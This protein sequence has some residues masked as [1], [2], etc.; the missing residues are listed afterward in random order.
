VNSL[1]GTP[2][3]YAL[4]QAGQG[5]KLSDQNGNF[6][7]EDISTN[8][9]NVAAHKPGF[10]NEQELSQGQGQRVGRV[11]PQANTMVSLSNEPTNITIPLT[12]E[13]VIS[14]HVENSEGEPLEGLPVQ[15]RTTQ[16]VNG[17][18]MWQ[19][20]GGVATD[21]DG[22][23]RVAN[24]RPGTYYV[25]VGPNFS[26]RAMQQ[27][28]AANEKLEV[29]PAEYYPGVRDM[30]AAT[31][32]SLNPGQHASIEMGMKRVPGYRIS[33]MITGIASKFGGIFLADGDGDNTSLGMRF[34]PQTGRFQ[35]YPVPAGSYRLRFN[36][37][38]AD[39]Q[40][41]FTD[42]PI[43]VNGDILELRVPV[44]RTVSIPVEFNTELTKQ[45]PGSSTNLSQ[46]VVANSSYGQVHLVSRDP[47]YQQFYGS[48]DRADSSLTLRGVTPGVYDVEVDSNGSAYVAAI[49]YGG[50]NLLRDPLVVAEG[51]EPKTLQVLMRDDGASVTG[52]VQMGDDTQ[53]GSVLLVSEGDAASPPRQVG[54]DPSGAFRAQGIAPGDYDILAFDRLDGIEFR[55]REVLNAYLSHAAHVTLSADQQAKVTVDLIRT[56]E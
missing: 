52:S 1:T 42:V 44:E 54:V 48:R 36:G 27:E 19:R 24:L 15:L 5:A 7:F 8:R 41:L 21:E 43:N 56:R 12:P 9:I 32:M 39:G 11:S 26:P 25:E 22:N 51:A 33:G 30:S 17:R 3:P 29:V 55:N 31:P 18:R 46:G 38:D 53:P 49:T 14:G 2:I 23:F 34:D 28:P 20:Q 35:A 40:P 6:R 47:P 50:V 45:N 13:A 37:Q 4:V 10:F 16:V